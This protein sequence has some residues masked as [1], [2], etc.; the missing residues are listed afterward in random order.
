[1]SDN[2]PAE[3]HFALLFPGK[4]IPSWAYETIRYFDYHAYN[5]GEENVE[6][7]R[8]ERVIGTTH[9][10]YGLAANANL[11]EKVQQPRRRSD[12]GLTECPV[13][14]PPIRHVFNWSG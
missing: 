4:P 5:T 7:V 13:C 1:M 6:T 9:P 8:L 11:R 14:W 3:E 2:R 12:S 10:S